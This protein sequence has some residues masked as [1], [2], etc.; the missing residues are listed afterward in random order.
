MSFSRDRG[1]FVTALEYAEQLARLAP[2]DHSIARIPGVEGL[3]NDGSRASF[4]VMHKP[5]PRWM[6]ARR[7]LSRAAVG[8][9]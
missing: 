9:A 5:T 1:D 2:N 4:D 3:S 8:Q 6:R 7:A